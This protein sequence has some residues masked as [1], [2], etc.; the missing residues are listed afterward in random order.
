M[1]AVSRAIIIVVGIL[2]LL[3]ALAIVLLQAK[4]VGLIQPDFY[5]Y[6]LFPNELLK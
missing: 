2:Q 1:A 4:A 5:C 6:S 3:M